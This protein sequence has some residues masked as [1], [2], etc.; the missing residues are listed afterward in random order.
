MGI[1]KQLCVRP[2]TYKIVTENC[3]KQYLREY[4]Q[5]RG[6]PITHDKIIFE[7]ARAVLDG[8]FRDGL[9]D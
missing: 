5:M 3:I 1:Y 4:P 9:D 2:K 8:E 7:M 6:I